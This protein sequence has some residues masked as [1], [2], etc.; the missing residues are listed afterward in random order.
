MSR[1]L[2]ARVLLLVLCLAV[3]V[4]VGLALRPGLWG[5]EI[6]SLAMATG[7]SLEHPAAAGDASQGDFVEP[8]QVVASGLFR[9]YAEH[10][11]PAASP[12]RVV[13]AVLLSDTNPPLYYL[14]LNVWTRAFGTGDVALRLCSVL[15]TVLAIPFIW[16]LGRDL[17]GERMG[18]TAALLFACSPVSLFYS[19]EGRMYAL[20][21]CLA[22]ALG[23][24]SLALHRRGARPALL[25]AWT[26]LAVCGLLTHYFFLFAWCAFV[27]WL[28]LFPG[29]MR[30]MAVTAL[31]G[32]TVLI[33]APWYIQVPASLARWRISGNWLDAPLPWP[34][35]LTR[36]FELAWSMLAGGSFWGGSP[37][38]DGALAVAYL[39]LALFLLR[40]GRLRRVFAPERLL[41]W[42]WVAAAVLGPF[43]FDIVRQTSASLVPRYV[44]AGFPGAMLLAALGIEQLPGRMHTAFTAL[45]LLAWTAGAW[46]I[47]AH[48]ARPEAAYVALDAEIGAWA[49]PSDLVLVHSIP[50]GLIGMARYLD[51]DVPMASWIAPL[52]LRRVPNDLELLLHGRRRLALIQVHNLAQPAPAEAWLRANARLE[53]REIYDGAADRLTSDTTALNPMLLAAL[54]EHKLIEI[55]Y[56]APANGDE[57]FPAR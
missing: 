12:R 44:L 57:F 6:F 7:H 39:I 42:G 53:R 55:F 31:A 13:R 35:G 32:A 37:A 29:R 17:G 40:A 22:A 54:R 48:R 34:R 8:R 26:T 28:A 18:W 11:T 1:P 9:R 50:S 43:V 56:F 45:V 41:L 46:P 51:R 19:I 24:T 14:L 3:M 36:P 33:V 23:W 2:P 47:L 16:L 25:A 4:R 15:W 27:A 5:D 21:W 52:G 30:R 10:D 20:L 38:V 49:G